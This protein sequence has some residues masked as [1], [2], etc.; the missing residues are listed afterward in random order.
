MPTGT[1]ISLQE[2]LASTYEPDCDYVDGH[3][4]ERNLGE[5]NHSRL[6]MRVGAY[7]LAHYGDRGIEVFPELRV[8]VKSHRFRVPDLCL[9]VG[10]PQE[11]ILTHPPFL[12]IEILSPE[13]RMSR[14]E[15]RINDYLAMGVRYVWVLDPETRQAFIATAAEG[16]R[17][18]KSGLLSTDGPRVELP[19]AEAFR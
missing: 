12:C 7:L 13:D 9:T 18:V 5:V 2:Y 15:T 1:L 4:E 6:Q 11:Q 19:L 14:V 8:Q 10:P 16:W 3:L 17:E